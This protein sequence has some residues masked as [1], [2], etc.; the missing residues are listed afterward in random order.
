MTQIEIFK[1]EFEK[2]VNNIPASIDSGAGYVIDEVYKILDS[3]DNMELPEGLEEAA[4]EYRQGEVDTGCDYIDDSDGDSLYHS[5]CLAD[6]FIAG[7][8]WQKVQDQKTI[9][10]AEDHAM[11][12]G[13]NKMEQQ[14]ME[15]AVEGKVIKSYNPVMKVGGPSLH[16]IELIY[17][18]EGKPYLV[19]GNKVRVIVIKED[20]K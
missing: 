12:A 15:K 5:A 7:A 8:E 6:A 19:A 10:L 13:M 2:M 20:E 14:M 4:E 11:M 9:E 17:P 16:G 1:Q 18:D 3:L